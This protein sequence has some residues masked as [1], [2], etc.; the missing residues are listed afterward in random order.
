MKKSPINASLNAVHRL[1]SNLGKS[2]KGQL[3]L[4]I[5]GALLALVIGALLTVPIVNAFLDS[6]RKTRVDANLQDMRTII[7]DVQRNFGTSNQYG[8]LT[9]AVAV[10]SNVI[11][12]RLRVAGTNTA[13]NSYN[14]NITLAPNT[15]T[16]AN[17]ST[18]LTWNRVPRADCADLV[19]GIEQLARG[20]LVNTTAVKV[21][22]GVIDAATIAT[23]CDS[24]AEVSIDV[25]FG[26]RG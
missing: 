23:Q 10:Q 9:T 3:G 13:Q 12:Q 25:I 24:S 19:Y 21:N 14:G 17:D 16:V 8:N 7:A 22:D 20:V 18:V 11:P 15:V 26:R 2:R 1:K 6:Q 4:S 5:L